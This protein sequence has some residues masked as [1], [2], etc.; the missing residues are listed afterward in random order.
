[1]YENDRIRLLFCNFWKLEN[2]YISLMENSRCGYE[3]QV[4]KQNTVINKLLLNG[5]AVADNGDISEVVNQY[6][7]LNSR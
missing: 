1:M 5:K 3:S 4:S 2:I 7:L 6:F